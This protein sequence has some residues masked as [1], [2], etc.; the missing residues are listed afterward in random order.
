M[1]ETANNCTTSTVVNTPPLLAAAT[2]CRTTAYRSRFRYVRL[3]AGADGRGYAHATDGVAAICAR[4]TDV[5]WPHATIYAHPDSLL[6]SVKSVLKGQRTTVINVTVDINN[7]MLCMTCGPNSSTVPLCADATLPR[8]EGTVPTTKL[9]ASIDVNPARLI[10][11]LN[12]FTSRNAVRIQVYAA[13]DPIVVTPDTA[14]VADGE[15]SLLM[16]CVP[17]AGA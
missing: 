3:C 17:K 13:K 4:I 10:Q 12:G 1:S 2:L 15:F 11:L 14:T 16:P 8:F 5:P 9:T 6:S 7:T